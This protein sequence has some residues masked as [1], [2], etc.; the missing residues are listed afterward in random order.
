MDNENRFR[1]DRKCFFNFCKTIYDFKNRKSFSEIILFVRVRT[2]DILLPEFDNSR[3]SE[4][5]R[6]RNSA[7]SVHRNNA[8]SRIWPSEY[9]RRRNPVTSGHR[10]RMPA[11]QILAESGRNPAMVRN[12]PDSATD[13]AGS[14]QNGRDP[15]G[16]G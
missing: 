10:R 5:R 3:S 13:P 16:S 12:Q 1:F 15:A 2:L 11:D 14:S 7:T 9:C 8:G 6:H 4:T